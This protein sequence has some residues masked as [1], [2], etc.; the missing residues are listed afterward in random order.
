VGESSRLLSHR[1]EGARSAG[2]DWAEVRHRLEAAQAAA[3][4]GWQPSAEETQRILRKRAQELA[5][6]ASARGEP[7]EF[8]EVVEFVVASERYG[9][10]SRHVREVYPLRDLTVLPSVP[11]YVLGVINLRGKIVSV[12]D[13]KRFF[14]LPEKGLSELNKVLI[15]AAAQMEL[16]VLADTVVGLRR[17]PL[18]ELQPSL[19]TLTEIRAEYLKGVCGDRL[20]V[21]DAEKILSDPKL[22]VHQ[23]VEL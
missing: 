13:L 23:Q 2:L 22:A 1:Q 3:E 10:E 20:V 4:Q 18:R 5:R 9:L 14:E 19:P 21:L 8:L 17:I 15:V 16:G 11:S 6:E 12:V 7:G